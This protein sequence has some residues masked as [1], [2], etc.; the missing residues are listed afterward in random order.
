[1]KTSNSAETAERMG[2]AMT[3]TSS[4]R[5]RRFKV[6]PHLLRL[7]SAPSASVAFTRRSALSAVAGQAL[8]ELAI[9][10]SL[11]LLV[12]GAVVNYGLNYD[13]NQR[14]SMEAFRQALGIAS[15][16]EVGSGA[17][18]LIQDRHLPSA[19]NPFAI[20]F[21]AQVSGSA[22]VTRNFKQIETADC[23]DI[24]ALPHTRLV[25]GGQEIDCPGAGLGCALQG[26]RV[27]QGV[28]KDSVQRYFTI[29]GDPNV[30][31]SPDGCHDGAEG[32]CAG[33]ACGDACLREETRPNPETGLPEVVCAE[34]GKNLVINDACEGEIIDFENC[35]KQARMLVDA[36]VCVKECEKAKSPSS[37][38]DCRDICG[39]PI[40]N[41]PWYAA[42]GPDPDGDGPQVGEPA[43]ELPGTHE[44]GTHQWV[45]PN[46]NAAFADIRTHGLQPSQVKRN[47][48]DNRL[49]KSED[50][51]R[52]ATTTVIDWEDETTRIVRRMDP[53]GKPLLYVHPLPESVVFV[54]VEQPICTTGNELPCTPGPDEPTTTTTWTTPW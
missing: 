9:F 42:N 29:Y 41:I 51:S 22:G 45:F 37:E 23:P 27:E 11:L 14:A 53:A 26:F 15:D 33:V 4:L 39:Q 35:V 17:Y 8:L 12:L 7:Q 40:P 1:M 16:P 10:G 25:I 24:A 6:V 36:E 48:I 50:A 43:R 3:S 30:T 44:D 20:G 31:D 34:E 49:E 21:R 52:I 18:T 38:M 5:A 19:S 32:L 46:L 54:S 47:T 13:Y 28:P 2:E